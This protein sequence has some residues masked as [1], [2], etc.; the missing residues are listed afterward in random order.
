MRAVRL[1]WRLW[2]RFGYD[3]R[4][5]AET[6]TS[7]VVAFADPVA[8]LAA[9]NSL[10]EQS[11]PPIEILVVDNH[12]SART[13]SAMS[14]WE[15]DSRVRLVHSGENLGYTTA[16]NRAA[17]QARGEWLFFLNPDA[18]A[19][20]ACL[21]TLLEA[22]DA[23]CGV[24]GAQVLLED[25]RTNAG[26]N[27][28]HITGIAWSGR[29]GESREHGYAREVGSVS[30]AALLARTQA[31]REVGGMCESFFMYEDDV[32]LCWRVRL[33]GWTVIFCPNAVVW[34]EYE[35][36]RGSRKWF[37]LERN[38]LWAVLS[39]YGAGTLVLLAPLLLGTELA[40]AALALRDGWARQL[41]RAWGSILLALP[42]LLRWRRRVQRRRRVPDSIVIRWT[43]GRF[44]TPLLDSPLAR[45]VN[46]L[47]E[48][49]RW[50]VLKLLSITGA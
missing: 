40:V 21:A 42:A 12:P 47:I 29:F 26:D 5:V 14:A 1:A 46:P 34:H 38:R 8:A 27:P 48:L 33:A 41:V 11:H 22:A 13:A 43:C 37:L 31:F 32:D 24:A 3:R 25:G 23:E 39:N 17:E 45:A 28:L 35:F 2:D 19:D 20:P 10:L 44:E 30:G 4:R 6:V 49:Y 50:V 15:V 9:V 16:C 7:V 36:E 18:R